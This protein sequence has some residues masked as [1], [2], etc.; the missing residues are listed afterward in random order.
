MFLFYTSIPIFKGQHLLGLSPFSLSFFCVRAPQSCS[1][2]LAGF[3]QDLCAVTFLRVGLIFSR[4]ITSNGYASLNS[5]L[6]KCQ[7]NCCSGSPELG[8]GYQNFYFQSVL[9][10]PVLASTK[11]DF[12]VVWWPTTYEVRST[13]T[14]QH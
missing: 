3:I 13:D 4:R 7:P 11:K 10:N 2:A 8:T 5:I 1:N 9:L 6:R 12:V 14:A